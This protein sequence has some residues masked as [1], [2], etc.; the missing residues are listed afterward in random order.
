MNYIHKYINTFIDKIASVIK[1]SIK[2]IFEDRIL[3]F[4]IIS[5]LILNLIMKW[6]AEMPLFNVR[7]ILFNFAWYTLIIGMSYKFSRYKSRL[8][9][10]IVVL[11][12]SYIMTLA[13]LIY[14]RYYESFLSISLIKQLSLFA[15]MPDADE[16]GTGLISV[17]DVLIVLAYFVSLFA[18]LRFTKGSKELYEQKHSRVRRFSRYTFYRMAGISFFTAILFLQGAQYSQVTKLW[19]RPI[20]VE[21]FGLV[22]YHIAD[23]F[24]SASLFIEP[25]LK[26]GD[27]Q[28]FLDFY[29]EKGLPGTNEYSG[30]FKNK[31][32]IVIHAESIEKFIINQSING[33]E[34]TPNFNRLANEG[35]YYSNMY[36]QESVGTSSDSEFV[37]ST[38]LLPVNNGTIFLTHFD[39]TYMT[40]QKLLQEQGYS[41]M[42]FHGNNGSFWNRE[43]MHQ[44]L[45]FDRLIDRGFYEPITE[46]ITIGL[47]I[48]DEVFFQRTIDNFLTAASEPYYAT[49]IT[50]TNHTPWGDTDKYVTYDENGEE[51]SFEC[52]NLDGT[53]LCN[54]FQSVHYADYALGKFI[55][56]LESRKMLEDTI[57]VI[58]GDHPANLK[59]S[60]L[61]QFYG[62]SLNK[63][64][65]KAQ[66]QVPFIIWNP[67]IE[68]PKVFDQTIGMLDA[69]PILQNM[70]G[71]HNPFNLGSDYNYAKDQNQGI[72]ATSIDPLSTHVVPFVNGDWTDGIIYYDSFRDDYIILNSEITSDFITSEYIALQSGRADDIITM[73]NLINKYNIIHEYYERLK[74]EEIV[75]GIK[76]N[77]R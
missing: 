68:E 44:Q 64:E 28:K 71:I 56:N 76:R 26:E 32:V 74:E 65:Y 2:M 15:A 19:N 9:Y 75:N 62:Y 12:F 17:F 6:S 10:F 48:S 54:Y 23:T 49:L 27:Y 13:N 46:D 66:Q 60:E 11:T 25:K 7:S 63:I 8:T 73:S 21:N 53:Q 37:F 14:F 30:I 41:T 18:I 40:T 57:V 59:V 29:E 55:D 77:N 58:Y 38:S 45:G 5:S 72:L 67:K 52:D 3:I 31:N 33:Q 42:S 22:N 70:L 36:S 51:E 1:N 39:R 24:K 34:I 69:A 43:V 20:V 35:Y 50:L 61:E 4:F 16:M 47:G